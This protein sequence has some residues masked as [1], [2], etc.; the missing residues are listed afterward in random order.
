MRHHKKTPLGKQ[1]RQ[2]LIAR[3]FGSNV[4]ARL[5][6]GSPVRLPEDD[7]A[8]AFAALW[9]ADRILRGAA[10]RLPPEIV[11]DVLGFPMNIWY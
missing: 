8:D 10:S 4:F 1:E 7:V 6:A 2:E 9:S 3:D 11:P 5:C